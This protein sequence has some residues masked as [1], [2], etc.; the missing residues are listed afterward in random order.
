MSF[1]TLKV[2]QSLIT[3]TLTW[4]L[5]NKKLMVATLNLLIAVQRTAIYSTNIYGSKLSN[6]K[7]SLI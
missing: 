4:M 1:H 7:C 3:T 5:D 6:T 2:L